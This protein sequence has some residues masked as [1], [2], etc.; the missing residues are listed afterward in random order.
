MS[1][2]G[3][4]LGCT[5]MIDDDAQK[6]FSLRLKPGLIT[7]GMFRHVRHPNYLGEM[8]VYGS[9]ALMVWHWLPFVV[10]AGLEFRQVGRD[11]F[12]PG[13]IRKLDEEVG[14]LTG[15]AA[16]RHAA[17]LDERGHALPGRPGGDSQLARRRAPRRSDR[18]RRRHRGRAPGLAVRQR[19][20][21]LAVQY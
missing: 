21:H 7:D 8:M 2:R 15:L 3:T 14:R 13:S 17:I 4:N 12:P 18:V 9:F 19:Y 5:V 10:L 11:D 20:G 16:L 1:S 6:Y